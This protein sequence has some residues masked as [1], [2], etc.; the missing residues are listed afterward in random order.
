MHL[1]ENTGDKTMGAVSSLL[2]AVNFRDRMSGNH[3]Y[4]VGL[5][6]LPGS[7]FTLP[8]SLLVVTGYLLASYATEIH[9]YNLHVTEYHAEYGYL[10]CAFLNA[11]IFYPLCYWWVSRNQ[12]RV[13][14]PPPPPPEL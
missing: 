1:D 4:G 3:A 6:G 2:L 12:R 14:E 13:S 10:V 5:G 9:G 7:L 8:L 11:F